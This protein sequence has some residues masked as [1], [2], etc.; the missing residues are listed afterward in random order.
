MTG[1]TADVNPAGA[2]QS[3]P[4]AVMDEFGLCFMSVSLSGHVATCNYS[5]SR[6]LSEPWLGSKHSVAHHVHESNWR[7]LFPLREFSFGVDSV[8]C[9]VHEC[10]IECIWTT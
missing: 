6:V 10:C 8:F 2:F 5:L 7:C 3:G 4:E 1:R 9:R